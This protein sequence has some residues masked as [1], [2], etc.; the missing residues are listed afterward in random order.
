[1]D[2]TVYFKK[3]MRNFSR[4]N[5]Y[6]L[7]SELREKSRQIVEMTNKANSTK[8]RL[9]L[10]LELSQRLEGLKMLIR[11]CKEVKAIYQS[12]DGKRNG[13]FLFDIAAM[14]VKD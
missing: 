10:L 12:K 6:N 8:D 5:K 7:G 2:V 9:P 3:I 13:L 1:M 14:F 4:Y 11:I